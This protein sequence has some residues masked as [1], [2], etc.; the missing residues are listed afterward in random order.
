MHYLKPMLGIAI[1][2]AD[3]RGLAQIALFLIIRISIQG[4]CILICLKWSNARI[5]EN[6]YSFYFIGTLYHDG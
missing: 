5:Y 2:D 6:K 1:K 3:F 4:L